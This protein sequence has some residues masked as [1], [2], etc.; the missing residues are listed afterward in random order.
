MNF[1]VGLSLLRFKVTTIDRWFFCLITLD[2]LFLPYI[3]FLSASLS[4]LLLPSWFL[5]RGHSVLR[6]K[7]VILVFVALL[8]IV[9]SFLFSFIKYPLGSYL[10]DGQPGGGSC[11]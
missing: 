1:G 3:R 4:M 9:I 5:L 7:S 2:L 8:L 10:R 11:A 6:D